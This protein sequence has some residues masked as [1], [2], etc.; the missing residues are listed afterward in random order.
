LEFVELLFL[1]ATQLC[2]RKPICAA[3][4]SRCCMGRYELVR[5]TAKA[6]WQEGIA[7]DEWSV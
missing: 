1:K 3:W 7:R 4:I 2:K 5:T 6:S